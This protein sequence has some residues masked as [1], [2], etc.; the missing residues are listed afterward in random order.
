MLAL[1]QGEGRQGGLLGVWHPQCF[2]E[3]VDKEIRMSSHL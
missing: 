2:P 3:N 1:S